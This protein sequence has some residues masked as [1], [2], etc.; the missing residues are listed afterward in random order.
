M[1]HF[2]TEDEEFELMYGDDLDLL[3]EQDNDDFDV[4]TVSKARKSLNFDTTSQT[5]QIEAEKDGP[6]QRVLEDSFET[7]LI[8]F[9]NGGASHDDGAAADNRKRT[10][11]DLFGDID[12]IL[13]DRETSIAKKPKLDKHKEDIEMI[14]RIV[15]MRRTNLHNQSLTVRARDKAKL[16]VERDK[17]N[18][19]YSVPKYPFVRV[20]RPDGEHVYVRCHSEE[21][22]KEETQR[23]MEEYNFGGIMGDSF[24]EVWNEA[25]QLLQAPNVESVEET[26]EIQM[27]DQKEQDKQLWV[28]LYKPRKYL[29]LLSDES[30]NRTMLR[31][32][33][34]WDKAVFN[35]RPKIRATPQMNENAKPFFKKFELSTKL[36]E[37]GRPEYKIALLCGAPGL[38]KTTLAHMVARHAGYNVVEINASDDRSIDF[39]KNALETATQMRSVVDRE[40]RPNCIVFDEIDGAPSASIDYLVKFVTG[41]A[42][43]KV[44]KGKKDSKQYVLKRPIICICNDVYVPALRPLR[45]ISFI[46]NFPPTS[47]TRLAERLM[48]IARRQQITTDLGAMIA[49]AEKSNHDIR[50]C[51]SVL[52]FFK[53]RNKPILLSDIYATDIGQKDVQKGLFTVWQEIFQFQKLKTEHNRQPRDLRKQ[54]TENVL[55]LISSFGDHERVA[56][57][58]Y[59]NFPLLSHK[60]LNV[61]G[62]CVALDWFCFNDLITRQVHETQNYVMTGYLNYAFVVWHL[63]FGSYHRTKLVYPSAGYEARVKETRRKATIAEVLRGMAPTVRC[64]N[65]V[66]PLVLDVLPL[67][68]RILAPPFKQVSLHLYTE[69]EKK[70]MLRVVGVMID[71]NLNYVQERTAEG[72]YQYNLE[73]NIE[74]FVIFDKSCTGRRMLSYSNKQLIAKEI[75]MEKMRRFEAFKVQNSKGVAEKSVAEAGSNKGDALPNHLQTLKAKV[76]KSKTS[77][78]N[79]VKKDFFGRVVQSAT[80]SFGKA[81]GAPKNDVWYS[82]K[83]GYSNAVRKKIKIASLL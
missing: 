27:L 45:Q 44:K 70:N 28:E 64:F 36:D 10:V 51:L 58:V 49:L 79:A 63:V 38:G 53:V 48:E 47:S 71:Y 18:L 5:D 16:N 82:Y 29:E 37:H 76:I 75:E 19:S 50:S 33:K 61:T 41:S 22:E 59:E 74:E 12:D 13:L 43:A 67:L 9:S 32:M 3:R 80:S 77:P 72:L 73:P 57:G 4:V 46:L 11:E 62:A 66:L 25:R 56:Q 78:K 42:T 7:D 40:R 6:S 26:D 17:Q 23:M 35:R 14:N 21:Y 30:I 55:R 39:F 83:E 69:E 54:R 60:N 81:D 65:Q 1:S 2:P 68:V 15:D 8:E 31:W 20:L 34:L 24:Q 52:H